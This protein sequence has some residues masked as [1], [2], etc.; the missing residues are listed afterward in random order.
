VDKEHIIN[1]IIRTARENRG[2]PLG[3]MRFENQTGIKYSDWYGKYWSKWSDAIKEAGYEPNSFNMPFDD[4]LLIKKLIELIRELGKFPTHGEIRVKA[5]N[6]KEFPSHTVFERFGN[7]QRMVNRIIEY[8]KK[9]GELNDI[10][11]ICKRVLNQSKDISNL[12]EDDSSMNYGFVYLMKFDKHYKIG[13]SNSAD[14]REYELKLL[15]PEKVELVHKIRTDDPVGI[16]AYWHKRFEDKRKK[17][18]WFALTGADVRAFKR[19]KFM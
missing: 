5:H 18:E 7:K 19:R 8:C 4:E 13:R 9:M 15:L 10:I 11:D 17:G 1:E 3:T 14:R 16:E 12:K 6:C 2:I